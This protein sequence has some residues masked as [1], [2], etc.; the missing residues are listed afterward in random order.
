MENIGRN[1]A[2]SRINN[3]SFGPDIPFERH[4][5]EY[6]S[7]S[8]VRRQTENANNWQ[9]G[10]GLFEIGLR[11]PFNMGLL[12]SRLD[13]ESCSY[14]SSFTKPLKL[15]FKAPEPYSDPIQ[16]MYKVGDDLRL[17]SLICQILQVIDQIWLNNGLDLRMVH[18]K[19]LPT[20]PN[21]G[22]IELALETFMLS[23]VACCVGTYILGLGDRHNE[24]IML[25]STGHMFH[26]DFAKVFGNGQKFLGINRDRVPFVFT[27]D[28]YHVIQTYNSLK[29]TENGIADMNF[30]N[31]FT[32]TCCKAY[33]IL[34][35]NMFV[36]FGLL[37]TAIQLGVPTVGPSALKYLNRVLQPTLTP[38]QAKQH[39]FGLIK[40]TLDSRSTQMNFLIHNLV[41]TQGGTQGTGSPGSLKQ[42]WDRDNSLRRS[43]GALASF[44]TGVDTGQDSSQPLVPLRNISS[45]NSLMLPSL[46][47]QSYMC[48]L[49][50]SRLSRRS[51]TLGSKT[52]S[53]SRSPSMILP[54]RPQFPP[55]PRKSLDIDARI[56]TFAE[57]IIQ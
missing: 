26:I 4:K 1:S 7:Y 39:F 18:F 37:E 48:A 30:E 32:D 9:S 5:N 45:S 50:R 19:A 25:R 29:K 53:R 11:M 13:V 27:Q 16:F 40:K 6:R 17:D 57:R 47:D 56:F 42:N 44:Y 22:I 31:K 14:F 36:I 35:E 20:G 2:I 54:A 49:E 10:G 55:E 15:V 38:D 24:N 33:N 34:R 23:T 51:V 21:A 43:S 8:T 46:D 28:M 41:K 12:V 52:L 3:G